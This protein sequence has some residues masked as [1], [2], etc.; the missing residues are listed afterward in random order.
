MSEVVLDSS[1]LFVIKMLLYYFTNL[2]C[3]YFRKNAYEHMKA[4]TGPAV[5]LRATD[6]CKIT[7]GGKTIT[8]L[9]G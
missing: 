4:G 6:L 7:E 1:F 5:K 3:F 8:E 9:T 2:S